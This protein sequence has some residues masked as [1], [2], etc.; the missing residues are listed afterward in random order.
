MMLDDI[1]LFSMLKNRLGYLNQREQ[2]IAQNIA[3]SDTPGFV[4]SDLKAFKLP[5]GPGPDGP[6]AVVPT[7]TSGVHLTGTLARKPDAWKPQST[8]DSETRLDGN[9]VVLEEEMM[10]MQDARLNY[11]TAL[12]L[13]QKSLSLI[14]MAI[15]TP[16]R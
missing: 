14:Q 1:P 2:V 4:P 3:N 13:Y 16:G 9:K 15:K 8:P 11:E 12:G 10:K 6:G 7:R 5:D